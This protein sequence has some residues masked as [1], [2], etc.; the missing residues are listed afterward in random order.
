VV[1]GEKVG[2]KGRGKT[3]HCGEIPK[4]KNLKRKE[5]V[6]VPPGKKKRNKRI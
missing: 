3:P 6:K 4:G 2:C 1:N 5:K